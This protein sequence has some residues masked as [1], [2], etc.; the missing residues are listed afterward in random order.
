[1]SVPHSRL[2]RVAVFT[3]TPNDSRFLRFIQIEAQVEPAVGERL[4]VGSSEVPQG[5]VE[6]VPVSI[7]WNDFALHPARAQ[8]RHWGRP[9]AVDLRA[10]GLAADVAANELRASPSR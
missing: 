9:H 7:P 1:L 8:R 4:T 10:G 6:D 2:P 5:S 3:D